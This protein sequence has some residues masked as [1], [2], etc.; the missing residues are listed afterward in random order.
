MIDL[1]CPACGK[2]FSVYPSRIKFSKAK[3]IAC[4]LACRPKPDFSQRNTKDEYQT[5]KVEF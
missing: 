2:I 1:V 4:S 5:V 3:T